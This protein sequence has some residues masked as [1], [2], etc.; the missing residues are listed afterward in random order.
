MRGEGEVEGVFIEFMH[1]ECVLRSCAEAIYGHAKKLI[2]LR[3]VN[4]IT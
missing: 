4:V 3:V 1:M 2:V